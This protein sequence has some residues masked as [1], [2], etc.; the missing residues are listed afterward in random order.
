MEQNVFSRPAAFI[1]AAN[2]SSGK[3]CEE[4]YGPGL[5]NLTPLLFIFFI[6]YRFALLFAVVT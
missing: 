4:F 5:H 1:T 3:E 2:V 6:I